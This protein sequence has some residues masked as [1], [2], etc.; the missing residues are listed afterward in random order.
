[1]TGWSENELVIGIRSLVFHVAS[2]LVTLVFL[3]LWPLI[4]S[5]QWLVWAI[6]RRYIAIQLWL[7]RVI[8]GLSYRVIGA[9]HVPDGPCI[10]AS[11]HEAMWETLF[12]PLVFDNPTVILKEEMLYPMLLK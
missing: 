12:L 2:A 10:L 11:R 8:C 6:I 3:L 1:M 4:L 7:L 5:P 9:E